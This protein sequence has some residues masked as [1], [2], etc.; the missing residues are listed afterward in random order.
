MFAGFPLSRT[1]SVMTCRLHG[2]YLYIVLKVKKAR[3]AGTLDA[4][5]LRDTATGLLPKIRAYMRLLGI[6]EVKAR[7]KV[8]W[9]DREG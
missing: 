6:H 7:A 3:D 4:S 8:L 2:I 5:S 9:T 1:S